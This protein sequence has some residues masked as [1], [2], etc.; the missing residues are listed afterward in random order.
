MPKIDISKE[1][2]QILLQMLNQANVRLDFADKMLKLRE[3]LKN[4]SQK[5]V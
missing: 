2:L 1:E 3:K 5:M 4:A